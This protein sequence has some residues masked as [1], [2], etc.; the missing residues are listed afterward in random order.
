MSAGIDIFGFCAAC[1][2]GA[3]L[4]VLVKRYSPEHAFLL[5]CAVVCSALLYLVPL[6][7]SLFEEISAAVGIS[8]LG[9]DFGCLVKV[10]GIGVVCSAAGNICRDAGQSSVAGAVDLC[11]RL[12]ALAAVLPMF[13]RL[14]NTIIGLMG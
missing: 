12:G 4:C 8:S 3:L 5:S 7:G 1:V 11:G 14:L 10:A 13:V 9:E 6:A 2:V